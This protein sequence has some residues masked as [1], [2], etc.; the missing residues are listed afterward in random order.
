VTVAACGGPAFAWSTNVRV[1]ES[2]FRVGINYLFGGPV[3]AKY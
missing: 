2:V 3:V 1:R